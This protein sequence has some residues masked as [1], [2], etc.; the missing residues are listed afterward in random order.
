[1]KAVM[2]P[3]VVLIQIPAVDFRVFLGVVEEATG[4]D[5]A[6]KS[7]GRRDVSPEAKFLDCLAL[8]RAGLRGDATCREWPRHLFAHLSFSALIGAEEGDLGD[9]LELC[10]GMAYTTAD[11]KMRGVRIAVV[12]GTLAQWREAVIAG[13]SESQ[14]TSVRHCFNC[15]H[16]LFVRRDLDVWSDYQPRAARDQTFLLSDKRR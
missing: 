9:V 1:M 7:P 15:L 4:A 5:L 10:T 2:R 12:T 13:C 3:D 6:A 14:P 16:T 8:L 11:T